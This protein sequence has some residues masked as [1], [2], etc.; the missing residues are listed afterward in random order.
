[1]NVVSPSVRQYGRVIVGSTHWGDHLV[2]RALEDISA[3]PEL[4]LSPSHSRN[5]LRGLSRLW[6]GW[7]GANMRDYV[8]ASCADGERHGVRLSKPA[9]IERQAALLSDY[10]QL[11]HEQTAKILNV[12]TNKVTQACLEFRKTK[13]HDGATVLLI[14]DDLLIAEAVRAQVETMGH[15][16]SCIAATAEHAIESAFSVTPD[17]IISDI[18]LADGTSGLNATR[19]INES[20]PVPTIYLTAFPEL[21]LTGASHEPEFVLS[22]PYLPTQLEAL[23]KHVLHWSPRVMAR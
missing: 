19:Q 14:E 21:V 11:P 7:F 22:K 1:M 23:M 15:H 13:I 16:C 17:L 18:K 20:V 5:V 2:A 6:N 8:S 10:R 4:G 9:G 3:D 12:P